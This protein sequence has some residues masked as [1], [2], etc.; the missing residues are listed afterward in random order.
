MVGFQW[1]FL[2][3]RVRLVTVC[4]DSKAFG[5]FRKISQVWF[6]F[7]AFWMVYGGFDAGIVNADFGDA[8]Q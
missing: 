4:C 8:L 3:A 1:E 5:V 2:R 6:H 7:C